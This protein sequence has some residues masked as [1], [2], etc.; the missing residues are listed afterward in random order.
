GL[1]AADIVITSAAS[2][3]YLV[4]RERVAAALPSRGG[5]PLLIVDIAVP[6]NVEPA[7]AD[8]PG[9]DLYNVDDLRDVR[10]ANLEQRRREA[11]RV[12]PIIDDEV[13]KY[14]HWWRAREVAPTIAALVRK[15]ENIRQDE[16]T[17]TLS[18]LGVLS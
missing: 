4:T 3:R 1:A 17:R 2:E 5:R 8:L 6:R 10:A 13:A 11:E 18:R 9:A 16:V 7:V 12:E 15:A 14:V